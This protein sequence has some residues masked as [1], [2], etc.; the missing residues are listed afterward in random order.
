MRVS[1]GQRR[2]GNRERGK[3]EAQQNQ[4][5]KRFC[6]EKALRHRQRDFS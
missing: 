5:A 3:T 1:F 6:A 2:I 4:T